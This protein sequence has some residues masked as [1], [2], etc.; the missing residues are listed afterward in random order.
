[1]KFIIAD[2][3][4]TG[5]NAHVAEMLSFGAFYVETGENGLLNFNSMKGI[6]RF[7]NIDKEVPAASSQINGLTRQI[8]FEKSNGDYLEDCFQELSEFVYNTD[9]VF[10]GYNVKFDLNIV[11]S[12]FLRCGL[13]EPR[14]GGIYDVMQEQKPLL[15]GTG[16]ETRKGVKLTTAADIIFRQRNVYTKEQLNQAFSVIVRR[17]ELG[18]PEA[19]YHS[20]LYDAFITMMILNR[21][22]L[23]KKS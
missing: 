18:E 4:A 9:A 15:I 10:T 17:L 11:R 12:N 21:I 7:F 3:E 8:C 13:E 19:Q 1:M 16:Y 23:Y 6:H 22:L 2:T 20:A 5:L 14:W